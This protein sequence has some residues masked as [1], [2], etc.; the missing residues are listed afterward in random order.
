L[1][2]WIVW[3]IL[4][5]LLFAVGYL[6]I[7]GAMSPLRPILIPLTAWR[8]AIGSWRTQRRI[9]LTVAFLV[10]VGAL[11]QLYFVNTSGH[12]EWTLLIASIFWQAL[13][14]TFVAALAVPL[15]LYV[16]R[17]DTRGLAGSWRNRA[18]RRRGAP[19]PAGPGLV[20]APGVSSDLAPEAPVAD[21][22][23]GGQKLMPLMLR[24]AAYGLAIWIFGYLVGVANKAA[25]LST[26]PSVP[27]ERFGLAFISFLITGLLALV[28]PALSL[29]MP[30]PLR[31]GVAMGWKRA[32]ALYVML[33]VVAAP[34]AVLTPLAILAPAAAWRPSLG[35]RL[36]S[37]TLISIVNVFQYLATEISTVL[38]AR[39]AMLLSHDEAE[40]AGG[41]GSMDLSIPASR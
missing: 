28:R 10:A 21:P 1:A 41:I 16:I 18:W 7:R 5:A 3:T 22:F 17:I 29:G 23:E 33:A 32:L 35:A 24:A 4:G 13:M 2:D 6:A 14:A 20:R 8:L 12:D 27:A 19:V 9:V 25:I 37:I 39:R 36:I 15:H 11:M 38:F 30:R 31:S 34:P 26:A 40:E